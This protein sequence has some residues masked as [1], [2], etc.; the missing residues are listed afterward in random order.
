MA[1]T[2]KDVAIEAGVSIATVSH[3]FNKT[4]FVSDE[5]VKRVQAAVDKLGY[6]PNVSAQGLRGNKTK[7]IGLL[8][9]S[10]SS[11][12]SVD[13]L[14]AIERILLKEGYQMVLGCSHENIEREKEQ[15]E[16]LNYQ[17]I[18]GL[19]LF[20]APGDHSYLDQMAR[21][22]PIVFLDRLAEGCI[23]DA[24]LGDNDN[25]TYMV[26]E[27]LIKAG[28]RNIGIITGTPGVS[29]FT[30]RLDGYK[31]ALEDNGIPFERAYVQDGYSTNE[32][33]YHA[34]EALVQDKRVTAAIILSPTMTPGCFR[35]L[36]KNGISI[37]ERMAIVGF[38]DTEWADI[39]SPP[40]TTMRHP[41]FEMG[42]VAAKQLLK[43]LK[44]D[45]HKKMLNGDF[46]V[47]PY[48]TIRLP[49]EIVRRRTF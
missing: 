32:G 44:E 17:Q 7:R 23:R 46:G 2:I 42:Q 40:L 24:V 30:E 12:F 27:E 20:P 16:I 31:R 49:L 14:D 37:P 48:T 8:V 10:I 13:I 45:H 41:L 35:C 22:Y 38:G 19:I 9:P 29:A 5:T 36:I 34:M 4:R 11:F 26:V 1:V 6:V 47:D 3:V 33:G 15:I 39:T 43:R 18:D 28:H 21:K 25:A